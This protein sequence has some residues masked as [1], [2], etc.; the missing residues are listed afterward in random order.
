M[1]RNEDSTVVDAEQEDFMEE[2]MNR[3]RVMARAVESHR[4]VTT[5]RRAIFAFVVCPR[6][7]SHLFV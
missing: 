3:V 5:A 6:Q 2:V 4:Q 7:R 1:A